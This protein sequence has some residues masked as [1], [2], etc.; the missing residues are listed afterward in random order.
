MD[1][2]LSECLYNAA[3]ILTVGMSLFKLLVLFPHRKD[4]LNLIRYLERK[5]LHA[6]YD[7]YEKMVLD[8]CKRTSTFFICTFTYSCHGAL[9]SYVL[10]PIIVNIGRNTSDRVLPVNMRADMLSMTPYFEILFL[11]QVLAIY[12]VGVVYF[13]S[14]NYLC[15]MNLHV[16]GQFRMLQ[17]RLKNMKSAIKT[18]KNKK[19]GEDKYYDTFK[20]FVQQH[21]ALIAY[22]DKLQEVF[23]FYSL[24][25]VFLFSLLI[26]FGGYMLLLADAHPAR[27]LIFV[28]HIFNSISQLFMFTYSC[29][30]IIHDST[31]VATAIYSAPWP[32]TPMNA[33]GR[34]LRRDLKLMMIRSNVP[35]CLT[36][37]GFFTVSLET[38]TKVLS[39]A[40]SYFTLL[41]GSSTDTP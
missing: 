19:N 12:Q 13:C 7:F 30:R 17:Y 26:C 36:G 35:C 11:F 10:H 16:A 8:T 20:T 41:R 18:S 27:R 6:D 3:N 40:L 29:D 38:Y 1:D 14:D 25:Q 22:C 2:N 23:G 15:I 5:F 34:T 21:Q 39:T 31:N 24:G 28:F 32:R 33:D 37:Y 9:I 4:F